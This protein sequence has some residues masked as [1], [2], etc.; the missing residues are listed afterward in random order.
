MQGRLVQQLG[1][2][3]WAMADCVAQVREVAGSGEFCLPV[4]PMP[5]GGALAAGCDNFEW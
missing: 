5:M 3:H 4:S 2:W 1:V